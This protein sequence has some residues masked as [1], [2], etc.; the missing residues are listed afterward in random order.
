MKTTGQSY[1]KDIPEY[2][3]RSLFG[4]K[5]KYLVDVVIQFLGD[6]CVKTKE[7]GQLLF[8]ETSQH[9]C[10]LNLLVWECVADLAHHVFMDF[11]IDTCS[12]RA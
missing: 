6:G 8:M 1:Q 11:I 7:C 5:M 9:G 3:Y 12:D 4:K 2:I 10:R